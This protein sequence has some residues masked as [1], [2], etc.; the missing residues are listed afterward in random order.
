MGVLSMAWEM[1][2]NS[3]CKVWLGEDVTSPS[4]ELMFTRRGC[5]ASDSNYEEGCKK[6]QEEKDTCTKDRLL[7]PNGRI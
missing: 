6:Y 7:D 4:S 2:F 3:A 1:C 5:L